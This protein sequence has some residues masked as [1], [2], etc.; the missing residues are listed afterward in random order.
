[1]QIERLLS[2][3]TLE[4]QVHEEVTYDDMHD[5]GENLWNF[6][7][8]TGYLKKESE[9]FKESA[10][11][12]RV[13]IPNTEVWTIYRDTIRNWM[14]AKMKKEDFRDLYRAM[15]DKNAEK[16]RDILNGQLFGTINFPRC[17]KS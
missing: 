7:L 4:I 11:F 12:L 13:K 16:M 2:G 1:M 3:E 15:E 17:H 10:V 9:Y 14:R 8:F 6:L 5:E